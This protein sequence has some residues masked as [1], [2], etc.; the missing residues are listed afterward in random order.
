LSKFLIAAL[1][2]LMALFV[3]A[4]GG[5][6]EGYFYPVTEATMITRAERD[7]DAWTRIWGQA[8]RRRACSFQRLEWRLGDDRAFSVVDLVFEEGAKVRGDGT[9]EFGPW[10]L[11]LSPDQL[12]KRSY[13]IVYHRC[14]WLWL[15]QTR[16]YR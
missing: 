9:F 5:A 3:Q 11:H 15:T 13:A 12:R 14:H 1:A 6:I 2:G 4:F 10:L 7:T 8:A 16:F